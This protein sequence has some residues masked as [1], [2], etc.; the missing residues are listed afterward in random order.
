MVILDDLHW[1]DRPTLL[2]VRHLAGL[3]LTRV[4]LVGAYRDPGQPDGPLIETLGALARQQT[5]IRIDP[6]RLSPAHAVALLAAAAGGDP[7]EAGSRLAEFLHHETEGNPFYLVEMLEHAKETG[8]IAE[9]AARE[10]ASNAGFSRLSLPDSIREVLRARVARLGPDAARLLPVAAVIGQEFD[11][12]LLAGVAGMDPGHVLDLLDAA[13]RAGLV[14]EPAPGM[15]QPEPAPAWGGRAGRFRFAHALVQHTLYADISPARRTRLHGQVARS[16]EAIGDRQPGE[17]AFHLLAGITPATASKAIRYARAA[18]ERALA[19]SA[20]DEAVRWYT[21]VLSTLPPPRDDAGHAQ[22]MI[23]LGTAQRLAGQPAYRDTL[24]TAARIAQDAGRGDLLAEAALASS[25]GSFSRLGEVDAEKIALIEAA[26][27]VVPPGSTQRARLL[28]NLSAELTWEPDHTRRLA[29]ADAAVAEA[30]RAGDPATLIFAIVRPGPARWV[31]ETSAERAKLFREAA[32]LAERSNDPIGRFEAINLLVPTLMEQASPD[33]YDDEL[34]A[35]AQTAT[36]VREPFMRWISLYIRGCVAIARG[37]LE[38]AEDQ[39][40]AALRTAR[41]GGL[42]EAEAAHDEQLYLIR[43]QQGRAGRN[44]GPLPDRRRPH[45]G[46]VHT[47]GRARTCRSDHRR[48]FQRSRRTP[49][50]RRPPLRQPLRPGLAWMHVPVGRRGSRTRRPRRRGHPLPDPRSMEVAV[51]DRR[52]T[53]HPRRQPRPRT[54][55]HPA[56]AARDRR[57]ALQRG[58]AHTRG[59]ALAVRHRNHCLALGPATARSRPPTGSHPPRLVRG[60]RATTR[61]QRHRAAIMTSASA[62][63]RPSIRSSRPASTAWPAR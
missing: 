6:P 40:A 39:A 2:L 25:R 43:W 16:M 57:P 9:L 31:P 15:A 58:H 23:D 35:A 28:A 4:L 17:L 30:R 60:H 5:V 22:A 18:G 48:P 50:G 34:D 11:L 38:L 10:P 29:L 14:S 26:L 13:G 44:A 12:D 41:D 47:P 8:M 61:A 21:A 3:R 33:S 24:L 42:P 45:P 49:P 54:P 59:G 32:D 27:A 56:R 19:T 62:R 51:R 52:A 7:D 36:E 20:P 63:P 37:Q 53:S 1:A 55:R 46:R